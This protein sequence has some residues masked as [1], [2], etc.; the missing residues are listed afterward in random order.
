MEVNIYDM[1]AVHWIHCNTCRH[2]RAVWWS[3][4]TG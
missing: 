2:C 3:R 4:K 1:I